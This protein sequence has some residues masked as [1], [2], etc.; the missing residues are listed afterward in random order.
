M[1]R[2]LPSPT[3]TTRLHAQLVVRSSG[4]SGAATPSS[5]TA[6][7]A[8]PLLLSPAQL[9]VERGKHN[10]PSTCCA[11]MVCQCTCMLHAKVFMQVTA[12]GL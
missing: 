7:M 2:L 3:A 1:L 12:Y 11:L 9:M 10:L 6:T 5:S 4:G 8:M